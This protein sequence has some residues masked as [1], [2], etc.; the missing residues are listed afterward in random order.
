MRWA[1]T[2]SG[3][4]ATPRSC[5]T[6]S[7]R[8]S[9]YADNAPIIVDRAEGHELDRRRRPPLPRRDLVAV[10]EHARPPR[11]RARRRAPRA[12]RPR[13]A[14]HDARQRQP[15]RGR[16]RRR[17]SPRVVPVDDPHFLF[18]SDGAVGG[19]A[20]AEDRVP[21]LGEPRR[22]RP[23]DVPRVRRRVPR[24]HHRRALGRR[25]R[26]RHRRV[27]PAAL[28]R[29]ARARASPI[30]TASTP[31][32]AMVARARRR[33]R[34]GD[35]RAARAGRGRACSS[36]TATAL[37]RARRRVPRA[38]RA[39]DLRRGRDRLR[40]HRHAVRVGAV[41][42]PPR[43]PRASA[44]ASPRGYL[45]M[46]ATVASGR[47][48]DAFLGPDL[49]ERTLYHGHSYGGNAL[50]AAVAL[51]HLEL[52]DAWD[53]LANVRARS[54]ELRGAARRPRRAASRGARGAPAR[55]DGRR[56]AR[57]AGAT[58][59][60]GAGA[61]ARPRCERG[62]LLR[63]LGDVVVLMPPLTITSPELHR[64]VHALADA[65]DEVVRRPRPADGRDAGTTWADGEAGGIRAAGQW[66]AP[67]DLDAAGPEGKLAPDGRPVVSFASNDYLGLTQ[68]PAVVAAAHAALDRWGTGA[69]LGPPH[70]RLPPGARRAR[71]R[72]RRLEGHRARGALP[73]RLRRQ[74]RRAHHLRRARTCSSC[75]D[76]LNHASIIDGCR[77]AR[78]RRRG[79]PPPRRSTHVDELL[80]RRRAHA[81]ALVVTDTVFSMDGDV[82]PR[83]R[84]SPTCARAT[85]RCSCSTRPTRC[86][87]RRSTS[88]AD[89]DVLRVGTLSKT[90]GALGGFV[91]GPRAFTDLL[92]NRARS[93]HLHHRV[94][95][96]PTP[97]P[98]SPRCAVVRSPEGDALRDA[99]A[100]QRRP[101]PPRP[102]VADR[103]RSCAA[104]SAR[105][106][107]A[108]D[109]L[110]D[111]G[112]ARPRDPAADRA[113][114]AR[115]ACASRCRPRT[116]TSRS[117]GWRPR[118]P[119]SSPDGS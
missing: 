46:S 67:R 78:A 68:H 106:L 63:P 52:L 84:R 42:P 69:G 104:T 64:I 57:A 82:A 39:A 6:A 70:R 3:S 26:L 58:A 107:D 36:P 97:P 90:L 103:A 19:R 40:P 45:P 33:A 9:S 2:T 74:P 89:A 91:A 23:H 92:V 12:A 16:A 119:S 10:G 117:T 17:R 81:R 55:A 76:E 14:L 28:P 24:R 77:L 62:V 32:V 66:R 48:F 41:R 98:R 102:P 79:L 5:G 35:R 50:A 29:A 8:W 75:S 83:R 100:R 13:R 96:R 11:P 72:A 1:A 118:S 60:A 99:A 115:R 80:A 44:R 51:R 111:A 30:P 94:D 37:A 25:R 65:I 116:P 113:R 108:A 110:L 85:A 61:C 93:V 54:D 59:C 47:V 43:P 53:V 7:P 18:A 27:R 38:R 73:H 114:R 112:P 71:A 56:R 21:V 22:R 31:R 95:A 101:A 15:R 86:S 49:G 109:A 20:G 88:T 105:A 4:R 34:G 87:A